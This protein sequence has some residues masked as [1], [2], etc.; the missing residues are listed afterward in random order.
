MPYRRTSYR[1]RRT[2]RRKPG[3]YRIYKRAGRQLWK[4]VKMLKDAINV[5][6]KQHE[7]GITQAVINNTTTQ[8]SLLNGVPTGDDYGNRDGRQVRFKSIEIHAEVSANVSQ[9]SPSFIKCALIIDRDAESLP[10]WTDIYEY[11]TTYSPR[12]LNNRNR[13]VILKDWNITLY[14][15]RPATQIH[16]YRKIDMKTVYDGTGSTYSDISNNALYMVWISNLATVAPLSSGLC[17][18]RFLD[19]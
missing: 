12:N 9:T 5:E 17:R 3:R 19:N 13:F 4:D 2:I 6:Y 10:S 15:D 14:P 16:Y 1:R 7:V 8:V 18:L 11:A